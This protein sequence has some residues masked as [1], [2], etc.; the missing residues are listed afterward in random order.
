[1]SLIK[2]IHHVSMRT[3]TALEYKKVIEFYKDILGLPVAR[4]WK[5]GI[6]FDTGTGII[7]VF[8]D[9]ENVLPKGVIEHFAFAVDD[10]DACVKAVSEAGYE[11]FKEPKDILIPSTPEFPARMAFCYGPLGEEIEFFQER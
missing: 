1:M 4:E 6:M 9:G 2:G 5:T 11:V 3:A 10:V 8:N 7:E